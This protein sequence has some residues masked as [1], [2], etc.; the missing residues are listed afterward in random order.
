MSWGS[1]SHTLSLTG[2]SQRYDVMKC[3]LPAT[4]SIFATP[5][6]TI[7]PLALEERHMPLVKDLM[8]RAESGKVRPLAFAPFSGLLLRNLN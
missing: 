8:S 7:Q 5:A 6:V 2:V 4:M 3:V 1:T